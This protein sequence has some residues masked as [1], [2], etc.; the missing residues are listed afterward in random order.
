MTV[1][2]PGPKWT[3]V[4]T[5]GLIRV[6]GWV[7]SVVLGLRV[8]RNTSLY[9]APGG[10]SLGEVAMGQLVHLVKVQGPWARVRFMGYLPLEAWVKR[11][12]LGTGPTSQ[13]RLRGRFPGGSSMVVSAG[14]IHGAANGARIGELTDEGRIYRVRV[15]GRWSQIAMYDYS[16]IELQAWVPTDRLRWGG[17]PWYG[18]GYY[19]SNCK[20]GQSGSQVALA[21]FKVYATRDDAWP[22]IR[23]LPGARFNLAASRNGWV[24]ISS[25]SCISFT[26][27]AE[28]RPGDWTPSHLYR[29]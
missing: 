4:E 17:Y 22:T 26:A 20:V 9:G 27:F 6:R 3:Q 14:P 8:Q 16:R 19:T 24:Q 18:T 12:E 15:V 21:G 10:K 5:S 7:P 25:A 2:Q 1:V 29:R 23:I 28:E 11:G 13:G